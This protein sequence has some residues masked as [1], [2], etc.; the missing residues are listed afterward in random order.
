MMP[1]DDVMIRG[2]WYIEKSDDF[3]SFSGEF[4]CHLFTWSD[5]F[6]CCLFDLSGNMTMIPIMMS[7][8]IQIACRL[9]LCSSCCGIS[10]FWPVFHPLSFSFF[11]LCSICVCSCFYFFLASLE[12]IWDW[13]WAIFGRNW[14]KIRQNMK[15]VDYKS[16]VL[17]SSSGWAYM[18]IITVFEPRHRSP[19][20]RLVLWFHFIEAAFFHASISIWK[21]CTNIY[22]ICVKIHGIKFSVWATT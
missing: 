3:T 11:N 6:V 5:Q 9:R 10:E 16:G 22:M 20:T 17:I 19:T 12:L 1:L 13:N 8:S 2:F 14:C 4:P 15:T 18:F 7:I 21:L